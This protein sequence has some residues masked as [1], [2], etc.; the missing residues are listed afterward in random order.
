[1]R[2]S[3]ETIRIGF[4]RKRRVYNNTFTSEGEVAATVS[5]WEGSRQI[6]SGCWEEKDSVLEIWR[7]LQT[8]LQT[9]ELYRISLHPTVQSQYT[10]IPP[11][12]IDSSSPNFEETFGASWLAVL[13][14]VFED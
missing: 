1:M 5:L 14:I 10:N 7:S 13:M 11:H 3:I 12:K 8:Q 6:P 2:A 4:R 9:A